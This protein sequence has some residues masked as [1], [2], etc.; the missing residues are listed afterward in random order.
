[1]GTRL[2]AA[3]TQTTDTATV[4]TR[5]QQRARGG[6]GGG[7]LASLLT[8]CPM[9]GSVACPRSMTFERTTID[10]NRMQGLPC[11][12]GTR[13]TVR[14]VLGQLAAG[15]SIDDVIADS[16]QFERAQALGALEYAAP[17][18]RDREIPL[19]AAG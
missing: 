9:D 10:P 4:G 11:I 13:V 8:S 3:R 7:C 16:P 5:S 17:A 1:M 14:A 19:T 18:T 2:R 12:H 15:R 6:V